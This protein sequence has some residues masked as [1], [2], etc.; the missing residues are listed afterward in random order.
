MAA[1]KQAPDA[2]IDAMLNQIKTA[3][4]ILVVQNYAFDDTFTTLTA[5]GNVLATVAA[6]MSPL[7]SAWVI[8][9]GPGTPPNTSGRVLTIPAYNGV[10]V[11]TTG[12]AGGVAICTASAILYVTT[13][14]AQALTSGNTVNLPPWTISVADPT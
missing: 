12:S 3:T 10:N 1:V 14:T 8:S 9:A 5:A 11:T 4:Q 6:P 13:C 7:A 2:T